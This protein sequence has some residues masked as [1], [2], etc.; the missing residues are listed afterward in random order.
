MLTNKQMS[1]KQLPVPGNDTDLGNLTIVPVA[2]DRTSRST[3]AVLGSTTSGEP[4]PR[5]PYLAALASEGERTRAAAEVVAAAANPALRKS[6][7]LCSAERAV[8]ERA[9]GAAGAKAVQCGTVCKGVGGFTPILFCWFW[10][11]GNSA[12]NWA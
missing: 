4:R 3:S 8:A 5:G 7:R 10:W 12:V 9:A 1:P 2:D 11:Y 6:A